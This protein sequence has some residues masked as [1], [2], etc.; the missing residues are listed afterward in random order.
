MIFKIEQCSYGREQFCNSSFEGKELIHDHLNL[1]NET[2]FS[3]AND[4]GI[5]VNFFLWPFL[6]R[7]VRTEP[8]VT[9][10]GFVYAEISFQAL[11]GEAFTLT[12]SRQAARAES[13]NID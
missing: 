5:L 3:S 7:S 10:I 1:S 6:S 11:L 2:I 8:S 12:R 4:H 13:Y 9:S